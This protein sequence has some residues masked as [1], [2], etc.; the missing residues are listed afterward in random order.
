MP[1][2]FNMVSVMTPR[3][4]VCHLQ[5]DPVTTFTLDFTAKFSIPGNLYKQDV[6][7]TEELKTALDMAMKKFIEQAKARKQL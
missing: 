7:Y 6:D 2:V 3:G 5:A 4:I 1:P